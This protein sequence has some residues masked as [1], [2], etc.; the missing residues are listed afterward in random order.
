KSD[1]LKKGVIINI[2]RTISAIQRAVEEAETQAG[3]EVDSVMAGISGGHI[4]SLN[5]RGMTGVSRNDREITQADVQRAIE[6]AKAVAIPIDREV[7]HV[8]PYGFI[9]D[10]QD[11]VRDPVGML[12]VRLEVDVHIV[13]GAVTSIQNLV[14]TVNRA[15]FDVDGVV[16]EP[17]A[18]AEAALTDDEKDLGVALIDI[19]GGTSD[20]VIYL[21]GSVRHS[22]VVSLGGEHVT[23][24]ISL[25]L[26]TPH[27]KAELVKLEHGCALVSM[28][29]N[30]QT[31]A[32]TSVGDRRDREV[33][34]RDLAEIIEYRMDEL[35][36]LIQ[37]EIQ[38][39][40][41]RDLIA[42]GVVLTGGAS[43]LPG[44]CEMS[45]EIFGCP[46]RIGTPRFIAN[47]EERKELDQPKYATLFGL[48][49]YALLQQD[50]KEKFGPAMFGAMGKLFSRVGSWMR[51]TL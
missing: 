41:Y 3:V 16:L 50:K 28:V 40:G 38:L 42:G 21:N 49:R 5:S 6:A 2:E 51:T 8:L 7:V 20:I 11:G 47:L 44:V 9:I 31:I 4:K 15:G 43:L 12:G 14:K 32:V 25:G 17:L 23:R 45:E 24:D 48:A 36:R 34:L 10:G 29:S 19:G 1:G 26:R 46:V 13:T 27:E 37:M 35:M 30:G 39:T 33:A 18:S 22:E